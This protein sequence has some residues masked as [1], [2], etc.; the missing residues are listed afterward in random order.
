M[1]LLVERTPLAVIEWDRNFRVS[2]WNRS[3]ERIF[4]F[5]KNEALG[6]HAREL[7]LPD[8]VVEV[9]DKVWQ[10]IITQHG[11]ERSSNE[12]KTKSGDIIICEWYN[13]VT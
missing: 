4:G 8:H 1:S 11:G 13:N 6:K 10:R 7:I 3:A 5:T 9:V 2:S 12:N